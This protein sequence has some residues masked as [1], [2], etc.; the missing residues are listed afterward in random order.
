MSSFDYNN[1]T[2]DV[3]GSYFE[4][5]GLV[6][7]QIGSYNDF[8]DHIFPTITK[9]YNPISILFQE[10][11]KKPKNKNKEKEDK[12][13]KQDKEENDD[14]KNDINSKIRIHYWWS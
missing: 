8:I 13:D 6:N 7:H 2:W 5:I 10:R 11:K 1:N 3:I 9:Q 14:N 12:E 4:N